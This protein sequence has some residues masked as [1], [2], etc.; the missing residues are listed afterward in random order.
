MN[1][2]LDELLKNNYTKKDLTDQ[3]RLITTDI[4]ANNHRPLG[5]KPSSNEKNL[6]TPDVISQLPTAVVT[7]AVSLPKEEVSR[8][9]Q[10]FRQNIGPKILLDLRQDK[11][12]VGGCQ[13]IWQ[14]LEG[15]FSLR[16]KLQPPIA[17]AKGGKNGS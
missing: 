8:L 17:L 14:G 3:L 10:W 7:L 15:D 9:G 6:I 2:Q 13:V 16:K 5:G 12:I 1:K 4:K 11:K